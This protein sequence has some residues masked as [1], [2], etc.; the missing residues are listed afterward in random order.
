MKNEQK[1]MLA[2]SAA[3]IIFGFSYLFSKMAM[4]VTEP[5]V[6]QQINADYPVPCSAVQIESNNG[7]RGF[8]RAV[9][10][11][12]RRERSTATVGWF[13]QTANK[14]ARILTAA[15]W[16]CSHVLMPEH[17]ADLWP[18]WWHHI[19]TFTADGHAEHDDAEDALSGVCEMMTRPKPR[20]ATI[21]AKPDN[22][23]FSNP[24]F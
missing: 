3:Y 21:R 12:L 9:A 2:A 11:I 6:A 1:G 17:W 15:P 5:M 19:V 23:H 20:K 22:R 18:D 4:E 16:L 7:G 10:E 8:A 14:K 13:T 24:H